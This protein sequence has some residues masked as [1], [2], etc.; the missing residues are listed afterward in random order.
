MMAPLVSVYI[1]VVWKGPRPTFR[2]SCIPQEKDRDMS[3]GM[4]CPCFWWH[5]EHFLCR[6][7]L[8]LQLREQEAASVQSDH[9]MAGR[10]GG[11]DTRAGRRESPICVRSV[12]YEMRSVRGEIAFGLVRMPRSKHSNVYNTCHATRSN[13]KHTL[14]MTNFFLPFR[15]P[16]HR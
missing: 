3:R 7:V 15:Y 9:V 12:A 16:M 2:R 1:E 4:R 6:H 13:M 8:L 10:S 14:P 11:K 5:W